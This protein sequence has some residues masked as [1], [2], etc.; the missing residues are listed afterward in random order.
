MFEEKKE[1]RHRKRVESDSREDPYASEN[2]DPGVPKAMFDA[3]TAAKK[4]DGSGNSDPWMPE[5]RGSPGEESTR[6]R[7]F[8][9]IEILIES[10]CQ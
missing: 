5:R 3:R 8:Q 1:R 9:E 4:A 2:S 6:T 7:T 10:G